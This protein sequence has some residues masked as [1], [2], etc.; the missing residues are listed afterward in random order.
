LLFQYDDLAEQYESKK[1]CF[2]Q[3]LKPILFR[4][5]T[6]YLETGGGVKKKWKSS[7]F[8]DKKNPARFVCS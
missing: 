5:R 1:K 7:S 8:K 3:E 2:E 4:N 6:E